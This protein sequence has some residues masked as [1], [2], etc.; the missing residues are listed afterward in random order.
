M[1]AALDDVRGVV[2]DTAFFDQVRR[3][4]ATAGAPAEARAGVDFLH[5]I[6]SWNWPEAAVSARALMASIDTVTWIP[7]ILLRNGAARKR[8]QRTKLV[9]RGLADKRRPTWL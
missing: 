7:D 5:G 4:A 9:R 2:V 3:F 8:K 1:R 6:G